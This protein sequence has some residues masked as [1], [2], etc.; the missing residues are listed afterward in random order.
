MPPA[1]SIDAIAS[2]EELVRFAAFATE[3]E[4]AGLDVIRLIS[5]ITAFTVGLFI[6]STIGSTAPQWSLIVRH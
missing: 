2:I 1:I 4:P 3:R 5:R 6:A